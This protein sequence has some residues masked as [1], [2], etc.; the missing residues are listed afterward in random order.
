M[1]VPVLMNM[2][3]IVIVIS[4]S[5]RVV[6][7][8]FIVNASSLILSTVLMVPRMLMMLMNMNS[9]VVKINF[10]PPDIPA[11]TLIIGLKMIFPPVVKRI[12]ESFLM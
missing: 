5:V 8:S 4:L 7:P 1:L 10:V 6:M 2:M 11:A 3:Q 9:S 12:K